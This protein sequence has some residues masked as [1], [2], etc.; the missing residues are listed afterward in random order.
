MDIFHF[1]LKYTPFWAIPLI[2]ICLEFAYIYWLK[3]IREVAKAF[4]AV[5]ILCLITLGYYIWAGGPEG[6]VKR[7]QGTTIFIKKE[8]DQEKQNPFYK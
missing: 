8:I 4:M 5:V 6:I 3:S 2:M 1:I 7:T